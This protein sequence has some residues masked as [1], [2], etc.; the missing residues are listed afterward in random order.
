MVLA[1]FA[2]GGR[3]KLYRPG[4]SPFRVM[5]GPRLL[6]QRLAGIRPAVTGTVMA[7]RCD[8]SGS[9]RRGSEDVLL[10]SSLV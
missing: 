10:H 7:K 2:A 4:A 6:G 8:A 1:R 9:P 3:C 5:T